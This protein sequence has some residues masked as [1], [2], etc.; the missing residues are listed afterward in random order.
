MGTTP[1]GNHCLLIDKVGPQHT[2]DYQLVAKNDMG[3]NATNARLTVS[4][5]F[6]CKV[7]KEIDVNGQFII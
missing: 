6:H 2:G 4:R 1:E 7:T 5:K 3:E